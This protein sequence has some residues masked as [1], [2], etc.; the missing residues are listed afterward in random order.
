MTDD[1]AGRDGQRPTPTQGVPASLAAYARPATL[2]RPTAGDP[3][4]RDS[5]VGGP[6][7]WPADEPWPVCRAPHV[8][9]KRERLSEGDRELWQEYDRRMKARRR[10]RTPGAS[11]M[12]EEEDAARTRIMDGAAALDLKTWERIRTVSEHPR[13]PAP[14]IPVLQLRTQDVPD[15]PVPEG[16]DLLQLLWCPDEHAEPPGQPRYWGPNA[17]LRYRAS[18]S[19]DEPVGPPRPARA[20]DVY[21]PRPCVLAPIRV[22]DLPEEGDLPAEI[23]ET[24]HA[25][26]EARG[27]AYARR[28]ACLPGW[29]AGGWPSWHLTDLVRID[30]ACGAR[31]RLLLT[32]DS[33]GDPRLNMGRSGELRVF[34]CPEDLTHPFRL[35]MQ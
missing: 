28:L 12:T 29:K 16:T 22:V 27:V 34:T 19:V 32:L 21:T 4:P 11:V 3:G 10:A 14:M 25:W 26:A 24:A 15:L 5:S 31:M 17:E 7:L 6:M 13:T 9:R 33:G 1:N 2:L 35:G 18:E 23:V 20:K 30:C 8:V